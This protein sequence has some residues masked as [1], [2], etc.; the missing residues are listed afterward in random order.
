M[1]HSHGPGHVSRNGAECGRSISRPRS[2]SVVGA[3]PS[4]VTAFRG[5]RLLA[6]AP[7]KASGLG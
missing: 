1:S 2:Q 3:P 6:N 7:G 5:G 4:L